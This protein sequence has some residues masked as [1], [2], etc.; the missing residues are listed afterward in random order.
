MTRVTIWTDNCAKQ[1]KYRLGNVTAVRVHVEHHYFG[2][3]HGKNLS[4]AEGG[5]TKEF[6]RMMVLNMT[7]RI[8][9]SRDLYLKLS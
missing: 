1:F 5:I 4:D 2:A 9:S 6:V 8:A 3:C 7:W